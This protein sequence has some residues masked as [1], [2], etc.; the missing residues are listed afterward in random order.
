MTL[1]DF[2]LKKHYNIVSKL[3]VRLKNLNIRKKRNEWIWTLQR[4]LRND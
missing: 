2:S 3:L 1:Q 4:D